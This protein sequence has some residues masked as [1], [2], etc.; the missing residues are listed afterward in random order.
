[1]AYLRSLIRLSQP[2]R[3]PVPL[4]LSEATVRAGDREREEGR[5]TC[6][7]MPALNEMSSAHTYMHTYIDACV[8]LYMSA[9]LLTHTYAV[10]HTPSR[11]A[12]LSVT[13]VESVG[14]SVDR[15]VSQL[16]D[17]SVCFL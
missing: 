11:E 7:L 3:R 1:M 10:S 12:A 14:R 5:Q 9:R 8:H 13:A 15:S 17:Q 6:S 16:V 2:S 4:L